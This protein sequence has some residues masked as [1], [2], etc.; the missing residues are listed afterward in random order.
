MNT[1]TGASTGFGLTLT[2]RILAR[3]DSVV[4]TARTLSRFD[5]LLSDP[6][7]DLKRIQ[8]LELDVTSPSSV[9]QGVVKSAIDH[10]GRIDVVVNNAGTGGGVGPSEELG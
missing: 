9:I 5:P 2:K 10:F 6:N 4:A 1:P 7:T 8:V 3:G